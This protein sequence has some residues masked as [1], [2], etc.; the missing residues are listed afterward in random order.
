MRTVLFLMLCL[1]VV[2]CTAQITGMAISQPEAKHMNVLFIIAQKDFR[3]E[4]LA[5]PKK[6]L[7]KAGHSTRIAS[8]T[9]ATATGMMGMKV[10]PDMSVA[11]VSV[12][13]FDMVVVIGG[14][15]APSLADYP[16]VLKLLQDADRDHKF[17]TAICIGPTILAKAGILSG[18]RA[19]V[20]PTDEAIAQIEDGGAV[21]LN[22]A[23]VRDGKI[24]TANGP[25]ASHEFGAELVSA[26]SE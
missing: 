13:D 18:K 16:E 21:Y 19:T 5:E 3:D 17:V 23:V 24:I 1:V 20:F 4:E 11:N 10:T 26:L 6:A 22:E 9:T 15:G 8:L 12:D 14:K 2:G 25:A 7:E